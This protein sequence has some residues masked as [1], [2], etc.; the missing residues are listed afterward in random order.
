[1]KMGCTETL[2]HQ[3]S[4]ANGSHDILY[5]AKRIVSPQKIKF[6]IWRTEKCRFIP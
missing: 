6:F 4:S 5:L 3:K 1:M 2:E